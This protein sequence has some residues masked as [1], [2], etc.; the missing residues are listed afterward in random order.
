MRSS[1]LVAAFA[2]AMLTTARPAA[3]E[4]NALG[5]GVDR[6]VL[7]APGAGWVAMDSLAMQGR[8]SGTFAMTLDYAHDPL[9]IP[10]AGA[11]PLPVVENELRAELGI[12]ATYDRYRVS[13]GFD[14][15]LVLAGS[16]GVVGT[17]VYTAPDV[18]PSTRPD[19]L[20]DVRLGLDARL[21]GAADGPFRA[22]LGLQLFAPSGERAS[23]VSDHTYR[24]MVRLLVAG[25]RGR[26][27][28]AG[29]VGAHV[30]PLDEPS[31]PGSPRGSE[32]LFGAA[33][34]ATF[35]PCADCEMRLVVGPELHGASAFRSLF[36]RNE[37]AL[38]ALLGARLEGTAED[39]LQLRFKLG[40]GTGNASFGAPDA[41]VVLGIELFE[42]FSKR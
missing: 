32:L 40:V 23:Y 35:L 22:G 33:G 12:A 9:R 4:Q 11:R 3:A 15:P 30:R 39:R 31:V 8:L 29:H 18:N 26:L 7:S 37:T 20:G 5:H 34:G 38:E 24:A 6:L 41:R 16:N 36:G 25:D 10:F 27:M 19:T 17:R 13:L 14:A 21:Y 2:L 42:I 28:Y 1:E